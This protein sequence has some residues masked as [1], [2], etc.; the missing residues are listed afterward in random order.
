MVQ[1][2]NFHV[3]RAETVQEPRIHSGE[4]FLMWDYLV[5]RYD[6]IQMIQLFQNFAHDENWILL[7]ICAT[8]VK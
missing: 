2:G 7:I 4:A 5:S 8:S 3:G 1:I 6:F